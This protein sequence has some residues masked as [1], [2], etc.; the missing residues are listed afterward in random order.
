MQKAIREVLNGNCVV[1]PTS[2]L[3]ALGCILTSNALDN[4]YEL[5]KRS[6]D[7][8]VSIAVSDLEQA[9]DLV[10]LTD[11]LEDFISAFPEGSVTIILRAKKPLDERL[12][13]E[14]IAIRIL[15]NPIAKKFVKQTG[16]ITATSANI[17]GLIPDND[18]E[19]AAESLSNTANEIAYISGICT[20]GVPSTLIAW[21]TV[22]KSPNSREI[23][24]LREGLVKSKEVLE[25]W[26]KQI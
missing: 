14:N 21:H 24:V 11:D 19:T 8:I 4:L 5:K 1:Y 20:G 2:T 16:P 9:S 18:C 13:G 3:P 23:E 26:K 12:G 10:Y 15:S 22:C 17:S 7:M 25:W 6:H